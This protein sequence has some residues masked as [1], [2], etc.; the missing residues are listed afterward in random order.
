M[1]APAA[2]SARYRAVLLVAASALALGVATALMLLVRGRLDKA[3]V[4]LIYLVV[5]LGGSAASGR[6]VGLSLAGAAFLLFNYFFL[7]PYNTL[8]IADPL[9]WLVLVAFLVTSAVAAELLHRQ[10]RQASIAA[11]RADEL[12]QIATLGAETLNAPRAEQAL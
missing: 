9:D 10:R 12:D 7:P 1:T 8:V 4:T 11:A 5:V 6:R 3:H 2:P